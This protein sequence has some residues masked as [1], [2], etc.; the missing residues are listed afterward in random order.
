M[1]RVSVRTLTLLLLL[2]ASVLAQQYVKLVPS[3]QADVIWLAVGDP[4]DPNEA[5]GPE[6]GF[7]TRCR[8]WLDTDP[9]D[10]NAVLLRASLALAQDR[11]DVVEADLVTLAG[12][13]RP[14]ASFLLSGPEQL[15]SALAATASAES[16]GESVVPNPGGG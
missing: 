10:P 12:L 4:N 16:S 14:T 5:P 7:S 2:L 15:E 11:T 1:Q 8:T 3:A 9:T 6:C 13:T